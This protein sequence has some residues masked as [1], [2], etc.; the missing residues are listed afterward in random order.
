MESAVKRKYKI[1]FEDKVAAYDIRDA[2]ARKTRW[3]AMTHMKEMCAGKFRV[4][5]GVLG[6]EGVGWRKQSSILRFILLIN[7]YY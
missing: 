4:G 2:V 7:P 1:A 3:K 6:E 5:M